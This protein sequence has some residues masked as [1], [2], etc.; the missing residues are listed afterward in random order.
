M[1]SCH[2]GK[3]DR[4]Y[5]LLKKNQ[6]FSLRFDHIKIF[7]FSKDEQY[8]IKKCHL[9]RNHTSKVSYNEKPVKRFFFFTYQDIALLFNQN[10]TIVSLKTTQDDFYITLPKY[11][12][13]TIK[14]SVFN[15]TTTPHLIFLLSLLSQSN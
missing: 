13:V 2:V 6:T 15:K 9:Y 4:L 3:L 5:F 10:K 7:C 8:N 12:Y 14:Y 1:F 11:H